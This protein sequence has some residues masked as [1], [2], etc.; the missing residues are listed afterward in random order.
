MGNECADAVT[1][2]AFR[3]VRVFPFARAGVPLASRYLASVAVTCMLFMIGGIAAAQPT[4]TISPPVVKGQPSS[5]AAPSAARD[6]SEAKRIEVEREFRMNRIVV[7][8]F[9]HPDDRTPRPE[10]L[11]QRFSTSLNRGSPELVV[12]KIYDG[13]YYDGSYFS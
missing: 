4:V 11:E 1:H 8:G 6:Q 10:A 12:G 7:E 3:D 5:T 2:R 13:C 9:R